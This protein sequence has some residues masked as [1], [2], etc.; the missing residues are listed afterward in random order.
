VRSQKTILKL[1]QFEK[2]TKPLR[3]NKLERF[4]LKKS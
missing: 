4:S 3:E 1:E 2:L